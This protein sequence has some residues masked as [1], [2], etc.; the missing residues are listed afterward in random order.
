[1]SLGQAV[2]AVL[3]VWPAGVDYCRI[4]LPDGEGRMFLEVAAGPSR[5]A[6]G[7]VDVG[8]TLAWNGV[9][10]PGKEVS[11]VSEEHHDRDDRGN[12]AF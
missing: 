8:F 5:E 1:M 10:R 9:A 6:I 12:R 11:A 7:R 4:S 2:D 3:A